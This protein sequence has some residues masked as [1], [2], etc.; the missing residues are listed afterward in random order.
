MT[1]TAEKA[2]IGADMVQMVTSFRLDAE[3]LEKRGWLGSDQ[4]ERSSSRFKKA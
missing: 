4:V 3:L 2:N 1:W